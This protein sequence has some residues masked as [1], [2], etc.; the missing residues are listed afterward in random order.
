M[1]GI[2]VFNFKKTDKGPKIVALF[3]GLDPQ[4]KGSGK[5]IDVVLLSESL[6][7]SS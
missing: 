1:I 5:L 3:Q 7:E 2:N 4:D 6:G